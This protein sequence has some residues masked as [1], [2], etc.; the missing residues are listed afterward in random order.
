ML[1]RLSRA[2]FSAGTNSFPFFS[3]SSWFIR[4]KLSLKCFSI[5]SREAEKYWKANK[6][7]LRWLDSIRMKINR[8]AICLHR[9]LSEWICQLG[10][11]LLSARD[12]NQQ[13]QR[14]GETNKKWDVLKPK[15]WMIE[16]GWIV[17]RKKLL[18]CVD[19]MWLGMGSWHWQF[20]TDAMILFMVDI[21]W[22]DSWTTENKLSSLS[23]NF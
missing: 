11:L 17:W 12:D 2:I 9:F 1:L 6:I 23:L 18:I 3:F 19:D 10:W 4:V 5:Q 15:G 7:R 13:S 20:K 8:N 21:G 14:V 22:M 16:T